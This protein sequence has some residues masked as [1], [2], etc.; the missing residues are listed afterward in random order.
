MRSD[1]TTTPA[2]DRVGSGPMADEIEEE[3]RLGRRRLLDQGYDMLAWAES[4]PGSCAEF[5][6]TLRGLL[7]AR[8][9]NRDDVVE[10]FIERSVWLD[11]WPLPGDQR[12]AF[13]AGR[14][15]ASTLRHERP[16]PRHLVEDVSA[17]LITRSG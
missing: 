15:A 1:E 10:A 8:D 2:W 4:V 5:R 16:M 3:D 6:D 7:R 12:A 9:R 17:S 11:P 14:R 13:A